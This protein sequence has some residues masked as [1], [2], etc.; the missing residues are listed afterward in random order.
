MCVLAELSFR[1]ACFVL[2]LYPQGKAFAPPGCQ[3]GITTLHLAAFLSIS[4]FPYQAL[5]SVSWSHLVGLAPERNLQTGI[6]VFDLAKR[7]SFHGGVLYDLLSRC[8]GALLA[9]KDLSVSYGSVFLFVWYW[10]KRMSGQM[11]ILLLFF[12]KSLR[13]AVMHCSDF[14]E[15]KFIEN[16]IPHCKV[17]ILKKVHLICG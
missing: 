10:V 7:Y 11:G 12:Q 2:S 15:D 14:R 4:A 8:F 9:L 17:S 13:F 3:T 16:V 1:M 6:A 5:L